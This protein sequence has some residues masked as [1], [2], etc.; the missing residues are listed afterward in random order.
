MGDIIDINEEVRKTYVRDEPAIVI[1]ALGI[2]KLTCKNIKFS[3]ELFYE[4]HCFLYT[5]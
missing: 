5:F 1:D 4:F 2:R 3:L